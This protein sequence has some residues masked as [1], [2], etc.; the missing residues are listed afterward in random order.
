M[1]SKLLPCA[2]SN[3]CIFYLSL[4]DTLAQITAVHVHDLLLAFH[5]SLGSL[6]QPH[7]LAPVVAYTSKRIGVLQ[8]AL[9]LNPL[10]WRDGSVVQCCQEHRRLPLK[11]GRH[12]QSSSAF[13][14]IVICMSR[15]ACF[16][17]CFTENMPL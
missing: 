9:L 11:I 1:F 5:T 14:P 7:H 3:M 16:T 6:L 17:A 8:F 10:A 13:T 15:T 4:L 12:L 2:R